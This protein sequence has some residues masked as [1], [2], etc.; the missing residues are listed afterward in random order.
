VLIPLASVTDSLVTL[1]THIIRDVGLVGVL[2]MTMTSGVVGVPG[3]E[4][5]MLFAGF[6]VYQGNLSLVGIIVFGVLG[7]MIG[8]S[9]APIA[10]S[11]AGARR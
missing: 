11:T 5:T 6:D 3:S 8:A 1:A 7:D 4:P 2:I 9:I 10:G